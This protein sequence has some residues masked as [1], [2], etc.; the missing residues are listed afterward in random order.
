MEPFVETDHLR[1]DRNVVSD[2]EINDILNDI[3][4]YV[5]TFAKRCHVE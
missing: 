4:K 1:N 3:I 5:T 2:L